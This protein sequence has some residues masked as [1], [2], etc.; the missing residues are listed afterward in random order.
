M[1]RRIGK[2]GLRLR[3]PS[4]FDGERVQ[5][6]RARPKTIQ[7]E[8]RNA[9]GIVQTA[10]VVSWVPDEFEE[11]EPEG[12]ACPFVVATENG[13]HLARLRCFD[14]AVAMAHRWAKGIPGNEVGFL[15]E[16]TY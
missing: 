11:W 13:L 15:I 5:T 1:V 7:E 10:R 6:R 3:H 4:G 2:R 8:R 16:M 9:D 14:M 12:N